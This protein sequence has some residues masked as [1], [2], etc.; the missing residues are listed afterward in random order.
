MGSRVVDRRER[1]ARQ[2]HQPADPES[3]RLHLGGD[4]RWARSV[5]RH[6]VHGLQLGH[7]GRVAEQSD[8]LGSRS[9]RWHAV[10][11]HGTAPPG[12][13]PRR[14]LRTHQSRPRTRRRGDRD[15]SRGLDR[16]RLGRDHE[17]RWGHPRR[18]LR[19]CR[20][21][22]DLRLREIARAAQ[23]RQQLGGN[24][25]PRDLPHRSRRAGNARRGR[26]GA[27]RRHRRSHGRGP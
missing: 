25:A 11:V 4:V 1:T 3:L 2:L 8:S 24:R 5:R 18:S 12:P 20:A 14:Q 16:G 13:L 7:I 21:R 6:P 17:G 9:A 26:S 10:A 23:R 22:D 19:A 27:R 15:G